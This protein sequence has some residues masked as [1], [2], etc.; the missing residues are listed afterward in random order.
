M[1]NTIMNNEDW[2]NSFNSSEDK[3]GI[4][5]RNSKCVASIEVCL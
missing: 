4:I 5:E 1:N 3:L 2:F